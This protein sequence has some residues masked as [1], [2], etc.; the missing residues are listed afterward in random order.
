MTSV[1]TTSYLKAAL[2]PVL[3][4]WLSPS[5]WTQGCAACYTQAAGAGPRMIHAL[6]SGIFVL[7]FPPV[8]I[9]IA[10]AVVSYKKRN[11][12]EGKPSSNSESDPKS[13]PGG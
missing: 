1:I 9:C 13:Q 7:I 11:Q 12:F 2:L 10:I 4:I 3:V 8:A 5:A 6:R